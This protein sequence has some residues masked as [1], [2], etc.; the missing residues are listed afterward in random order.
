MPLFEGEVFAEISSV[1]Y[2][3]TLGLRFLA[4]V[5]SGFIIVAAIQATVYVGTASWACVVPE[6]LFLICQLLATMMAETFFHELPL[7]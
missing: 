7:A 6:H 1:F 3:Y 5:G 2:R 4:L